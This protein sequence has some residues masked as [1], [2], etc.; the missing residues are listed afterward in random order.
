MKSYA[1]YLRKSRADLDAEAR[2]EGETLSRHRDALTAYAKRRGLLITREYAEII[3]GDTIAAR[4]QMQQLLEDVKAG[5]YAGVIVNDLDRLGRGDSIDQEIIKLTFAAAHTLIITPTGDIDPASSADED[6]LDFRMFFA[7]MELRKISQRLTIGR[8][9]SAM[10]GNFCAPRVP[11]G[12]RKIRDSRR[13]T[14]EPDP[15]TAP[16]VRMIYE[17][18]A[19][20]EMGYDGIARR[21]NDMGVRTSLGNEWRRASVRSVL[22]NEMYIGR[23]VW[24]RFRSVAD[25][26]DGQRV[27]RLAKTGSASVAEDKYPAIIPRDLF[28]RVQA[29][30]AAS[31]SAAPVND[32]K[33]LTN[34][35]AGLLRCSLCGRVMEIRHGKVNPIAICRTPGCP[36]R[37]TYISVILDATLEIL[38]GWC[39]EYATPAPRQDDTADRRDAIR[40]QLDGIEAQITRAQELVETGVYTPG[41]YISRKTAL[42]GRRSALR[43]EMDNLSH[44][45]PEEARTVILPT[46]RRV[47][48]AF[49][50][51]QTVE[52]KNALL[53]SV[54]QRIEYSKTRAATRGADPASLLTLDVFP[55]IDV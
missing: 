53:K 11:F 44:K 50:S 17:W 19:S 36:T 26:R 48:D 20:G 33:T 24:G 49:P 41:E 54:V 27:K 35:L 30:F 18:Y 23:A 5:Q 43:A 29:M 45:S 32:G 6:M 25:I 42:E 31:R 40:H 34:P 1:L 2:G 46:V 47:L 39:A 3:S 14:L 10:E 37:G 7:R 38:S 52:E 22:R 51:A 15:D 55:R 4:P 21:L 9:R 16:L 13:A 28:E 8:E 12:Y